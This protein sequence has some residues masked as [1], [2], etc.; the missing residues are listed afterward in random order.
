MLVLFLGGCLSFSLARR[1]RRRRPRRRLLG[2]WPLELRRQQQR[3]W[4]C[5]SFSWDKWRR[6]RPRRRRLLGCWHH[7][8]RRLRKR[9]EHQWRR[10]ARIILEAVRR[11]RGHLRW[12]SLDR[13]FF[14]CLHQS[15]SLCCALGGRC[16]R[17]SGPRLVG[18]SLLPWMRGPPL[19]WRNNPSGRS[20]WN[21]KQ[22]VFPCL[23][24][25]A[26]QR[27]SPFGMAAINRIYGTREDLVQAASHRATSRP[28][29]HAAGATHY[30]SVYGAID[31]IDTLVP[32]MRIPH[33]SNCRPCS[34]R[35]P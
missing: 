12:R 9:N 34:L 32:H 22:L 2:C 8:A 19:F 25:H 1:P 35:A 15:L 26:V 14:D 7:P 21:A 11:R 20:S 13:Q 10:L 6:R 27:G 23:S 16:H 17:G 28:L 30:T 24:K 33:I 29:A 3:W 18:V 31:V 5:L 4:W